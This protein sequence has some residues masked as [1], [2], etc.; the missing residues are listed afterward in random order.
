[1]PDRARSPRARAPPA[2]RRSAPTP[3]ADRSTAARSSR[4]GACARSRS[5][6]GRVA[7]RQ[8]RR[9]VPSNGGAASASPGIEPWIASSSSALSPT[10]RASAPNT[11][12]PSQPSRAGWVETRPRLGFIPTSPQHAAGI[13]IDPPPSE[14]VAHG[15]MP[16]RHRRRR[17]ARGAARRPRR[18][19]GIARDPVGGARRPRE[20]HQLGDVRDPDRDRPG[21]AQPPDDLA[22]GALR[23]RNERDPRVTD[24]PATGMSSL[25]AIGTPASGPVGRLTSRRRRRAPRPPSSPGRR[26][27]S[28]RSPR[29]AARNSSTSS[30]GVTS[31]RRTMSASAPGP[32]NASSRSAVAVMPR[33]PS[34]ARGSPRDSDR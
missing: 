27:A 1:M 32:A 8:P 29:S 11:L 6:A 5:A 30:R 31:R 34:R 2:P 17:A 7:W 16:G 14:P 19:P 21:G 33:A 3:R 24:W 15:T 13:R 23:G 18:I 26:S 20:D 9:S 22:V 10:V 12:K 4:A 28:D 25:I